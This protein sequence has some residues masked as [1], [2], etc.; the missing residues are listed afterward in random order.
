MA[1]SKT[2]VTTGFQRRLFFLAI[3]FD[4]QEL[5]GFRGRLTYYF[6]F[7]GIGFAFLFVC[8]FVCFFIVWSRGIEVRRRRTMDAEAE[9]ADSAVNSG[10]NQ[11]GTRSKGGR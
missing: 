7:A 6:F 5:V 10:G 2:A 9:T 3:T 4:G 1:N 11:D 8:L